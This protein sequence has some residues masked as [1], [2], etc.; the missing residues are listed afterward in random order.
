MHSDTFAT[1]FQLHTWGYS[2]IPSG[3]GKSGKQPLVEW[4][5]YQIVQPSDQQMHDWGEAYGPKLWGV[6]TNST[7]AV[8]DADGE[9]VRAEVEVEMGSPHVVTPRKGGHWYISTSGHPLPTKTGVLPGVDIRGEGGFVNIVGGEYEILTLPHPDTLIPLDRVPERILAAINNTKLPLEDGQQIPDGQRNA[10]L[11]RMAGAMRRQGMTGHEI[12]SALLVV[13]DSR[14]QP[15]LNESEV[16][17]IATSA[18]RYH[19]NYSGNTSSYNSPF[20]QLSATERDKSV[21]KSVTES[22]ESLAPRVEQWVQQSSGWFDTSELDL[23]LEI[24]TA[25]DKA[26]RRQI[27]HRLRERGVIER[28]N[29][30]NKRY[31]KRDTN[32]RLIDFKAAGKRN[33]LSFGLQFDIHRLVNIY[34]GNVIV[35]AGAANAG[36]TGF[37]LNTIRMN[38]HDYSIYYQSSEMGAEELATRLEKFEGVGLEDWIFT[39]E[40]R[41]RDFADVIRPDCVNIIDYLEFDG[42]EYYRVADYLRA[43]H[44]KLSSGIAIVALQ[45]KRGAPVGRGGDF[46]LEKPRLYLS[47]DD[48]K[49]TI[50]KGKN[51]AGRTVNPNGLTC[52]FKLTDGCN[53]IVTRDWYR[54]DT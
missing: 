4:A 20:V 30:D 1:A 52:D 21:T 24:R 32:V 31:R 36:K 8:I 17:K 43:I 7:V 54:P 46:G 38:Q 28:H 42:G 33:P 44:D 35:I 14:C 25:E 29:R 50:V 49:L 48:G 18:T 11:I 10:T 15:P 23:E 16:N 27:L 6:V 45:K 13:N 9:D 53:F 51:W 2:V 5:P 22:Q 3:G 47:M 37:L 39:A 26:N 34:P 40:E 41:S 19:P 12:A